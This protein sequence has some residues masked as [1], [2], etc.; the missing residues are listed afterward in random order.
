MTALER[1][2][3]L[4]SFEPALRRLEEALS[5]PKTEWVRDASIH[6]FEFTFELAWK[7]AKR[8]A[9]RE[10]IVC[11]SPRQT[12]REAFKLGWIADDKIRLDMLEDRNR[13]TH[14]YKEEVAEA[15]YSRLPEYTRYLRHLLES[16]KRLPS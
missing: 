14:T 15:I 7:A 8:F 5:Q 13:T 4:S 9:E 12:F 10:G 6:R 2:A 3:I 1:Q 11:V 16:L